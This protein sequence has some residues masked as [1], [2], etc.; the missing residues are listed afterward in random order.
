MENNL[1]KQ[2]VCNMLKRPKSCGM[3][4]SETLQISLLLAAF[5]IGIV[6]GTILRLCTDTFSH[7]EMNPRAMM[8][9]YFPAEL[10]MRF[11]YFITVPF[12]VSSLVSGIGR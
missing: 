9:L 1:R 10:F 12:L 3:V 4:S 8:Y 5:V 2:R 11:I 7:P 6:L